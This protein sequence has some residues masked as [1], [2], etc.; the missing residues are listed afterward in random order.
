MLTVK[1]INTS[2]IQGGFNNDELE[3]IISAVVF[4]RNQLARQNKYAFRVGAEVQ[5]TS[6]RTGQTMIGLV[7][8]VNRKTMLVQVGSRIWRV[9]ANMLTQV[10]SA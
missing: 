6:N 3:S 10:K 7:N 2:I 5:F 4:A 9:P 1:E 8:K